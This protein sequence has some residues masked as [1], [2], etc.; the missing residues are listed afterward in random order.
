[1]QLLAQ[2]ATKRVGSAYKPKTWD[3]YKAMFMTFMAFCDF[4]AT[5]FMHNNGITIIAFIEL[6]CFNDLRFNSIQNYVSAIKSQMK[7]FKL[8]VYVFEHSK[9]KLMFKAVEHTNSKPP[10]FN[11]VFDL[12][13]LVNIVLLCELLSFTTMFQALYLLAF[14]VFFRMSSLV[15]V[16]K[17][18]FDIGK[19]LCRGDI[20]FEATQAIIIVK[21]LKTLQ[22]INKDTYVIIP[23]LNHNILCPIKAI[24]RMFIEFPAS[25]NAPSFTHHLGTLTQS[26][27]RTHLSKLLN[28]L[29]LDPK[30]F[31]FHTFRCSGTTLAFNNSESIQNIQRHGT[32]SSDTVYRYIISDPSKASKASD[33]FKTLFH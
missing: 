11:G 1:M 10:I 15:P 19:H 25:K 18:A 8:P 5:S 13:S 17:L 16:S 12:D 3:A 30:A 9:V 2:N 33:L 20:L 32:W 14:F 29:H 23:R 24:E 27:V 4:T 28:W 31:S 7:W 26:Q 22:S 6:L 21:W